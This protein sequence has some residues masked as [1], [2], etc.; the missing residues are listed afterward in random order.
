M[1]KRSKWCG[2]V[3]A[4]EVDR[5]IRI[6]GWVQRIRDHGGLIFIDLRDRT[7]IVQSV[8]DPA[9][10]PEAFKTAEGVRGEYVLEI[11]GVVRRRP[12]GT[13]NPNLKTGEVEVA[14][15]N[16][17]VLNVA[18]PPPFLIAD[19]TDVDEMVRLK[20]RYLDLRRP[21]MQRK[22]FLRHRVVKL[23]RDFMD[24]RGFI[25]V[26]TPIL[27][28]ST[29]EGAR[30]YLV[31]ARL[32][33][34]QFYALPQSPQ[35]LKQLLMVAGFER[36]FQI[37]RC[38]RDED[39]RAD[40]QPEFTQLDF[41]MSFIKQ[42]DIF[43]LTDD[44]FTE[45]VQKLS[46]KK[47]KFVK[48]FPRIKYSEAIE[49][50]GTDKPDLRFGM[51]LFDI[52]D[53]AAKTEFEVFRSVVEAGGHVKGIALPGCA[54]Y[55]RKEIDDL[56]EFSKNFGAKGLITIAVTEDGPRSS[57]SKF[58]TDGQMSAILERAN[59][60]KGDLLALVADKP[61]IVANALGRMRAELGKRLGLAS[62]DELAFCWI[63]DFPLVEW[64]EQDQRWDA[65]HHPFT[66][67]H[68]DDIPLLDTDPAKVRAW[69]YDIVCNGTELSS[70]SIRIHRR[71]IQEKVFKLLNYSEEEAQARF[72]HML[73][74]FE[75][76]APPHGG[77]APGI[78][79]I[80]MLLTDDDNI[81]EVIAF[82]KTSTGVDPMTSAPS[83]VDD[84]QLKE[85]HLRVVE[86]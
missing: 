76:G 75:F 79:R 86:D 8:I 80:V 66:S 22:M 60:K 49:R 67:P 4:A 81:R 7:G 74:A 47:M 21:E 65:M 25:E 55:S 33:P 23:I 82:P 9:K 71:D 10:S 6:D 15:S 5:E 51:E 77:F 26:E 16:V 54:A 19:Q 63:I 58:L 50:F 20:Y 14:V 39:P 62:K 18:K 42:E 12:K 38:F 31:P 32:Y 13:E 85:L 83:P 57:I 45:I 29:P 84:T 27:I 69:S 70:G 46:E 43:E 34:G 64:N 37:A 78:D 40:R 53:I 11:T 68:E 52:S 30:D 36:Y 1:L 61:A 44:L 73:E 2:E 24:G 17:E 59:A 48:P 56:T 35:Q 41:E 72:G 3:T 28:K